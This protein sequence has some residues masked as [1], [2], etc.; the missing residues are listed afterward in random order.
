VEGTP[1]H[2][3]PPGKE[4]EILSLPIYTYGGVGQEG[5]ALSVVAGSA[6]AVGGTQVP[7]SQVYQFNGLETPRE[8]LRRIA[9]Q[10]Q[11]VLPEGAR[12]LTRH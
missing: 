4:L 2:F 7:A 9:D 8:I 10:Q 6:P 5:T 12:A 3:A 11:A 1:L